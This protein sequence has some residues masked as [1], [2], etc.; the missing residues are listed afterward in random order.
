MGKVKTFLLLGGNLGDRRLNLEKAKSEIINRIG[1]VLEFSS[2]YET[3][4]WG[5]H[6]QP[7]FLNQVLLVNTNLSPE[8]LLFSCLEI[9]KKL[10][11]VRKVHWGER[12]IDIDILFI[13]DKIINTQRLT[14]PHPEVQNR[15]FTL[16]PLCELASDFIHPVLNANIEKLL[17]D[18]VDTLEARRLH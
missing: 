6:D 12:L 16:Q 17:M 13:E 9:E 4:A 18:C 11:R 1:E 10:G 14:V 7:D 15:R 8:E 3:E 2:L 5:V